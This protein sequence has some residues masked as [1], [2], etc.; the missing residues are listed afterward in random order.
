MTTT[1]DILIDIENNLKSKINIIIRNTKFTGEPIPNSS[2]VKYAILGKILT[3]TKL[4]ENTMNYGP[5]PD[6]I[7]YLVRCGAKVKEVQ[8]D[9]KDREAGESYLNL[10]RSILYML[11]M[12]ISIVLI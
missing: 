12:C 10:K 2:D 4:I 3:K 11:H 8:V 9:M 6:T 1:C 7:S 5:E